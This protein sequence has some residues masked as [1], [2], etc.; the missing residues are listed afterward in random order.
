MIRINPGIGAGHH[1]KVITAG[2]ETKF[3]IDPTSLDESAPCSKS[4]A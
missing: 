1:K 4:T 3:G 2:K